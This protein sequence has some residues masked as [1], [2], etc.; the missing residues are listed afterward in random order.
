MKLSVLM[1]VYHKES[2]AFLRQSLDSLTA[3]TIQVDEIVI[4]KDG[5]LGNELD[6]AIDSHRGKLP[7]T[8]V[9]LHENVGLGLAL[10]EGLIHCRGELV[11]RM[12]SDDVCVPDRFEK[13][14]PFLHQHPDVDVVGGAIAEFHSD[15]SKIESVRRMPSTAEQLNR[16]ARFRNPLNHMT[17]MFRK[18]SVLAAG[19][20]QGYA[21]FED[22]ELWV[23]MLMRG[24]RFCNLDDVLVYVRCGNGMQQRRGGLQ[25]LR[26]EVRLQQRFVKIGFLTKPQFLLNL[27]T[28]A[29]VRIVPAQLR[30]VV[31]QTMLRQQP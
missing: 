4:V 13:Q 12:D 16:L 26:E 28:R 14:L 6:C 5:P 17:V 18:A 29:P 19:N 9:Q 22:Y 3:Q 30:S 2:P 25:Y 24:Q 31:Y 7:I 1:S 21:G 8:P 11:A 15:C 23:R 20:Y 10:R 27:A